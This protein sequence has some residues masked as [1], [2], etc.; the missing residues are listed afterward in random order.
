MRGTCGAGDVRMSTRRQGFGL[1]IAVVTAAACGVGPRVSSSVPASA[2][3]SVP[4]LAGQPMTR[5]IV[6][7]DIPVAADLDGFCGTLEVPEDRSRPDGRAIELRVVV[8]PS[9]GSRPAPDPLFAV[10]GGPSE[11]S[12]TFFAWLPAH[13]AAV[14][15]TRD[16]ALADQRGGGGPNELVLPPIPATTG[17]AT[18]E[19]D[20]QVRA[21]STDALAQLD[22]DPRMYTS[23]V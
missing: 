1:L 11:A 10:A 13:Y 2:S 7:G 6:H 9:S 20:R 23:S 14:H 12:T 21:W 18:A 16:I 8:V 22:A 15:A 19:V 17:L 3:S 5:C 4:S